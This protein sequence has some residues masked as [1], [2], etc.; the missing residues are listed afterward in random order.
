MFLACLKSKITIKLKFYYSCRRQLLRSTA[1][2]NV[3]A[4]DWFQ[5]NSRPDSNIIVQ[6]EI[7]PLNNG[8]SFWNNK[9]STMTFKE[10]PVAK[11]W[12][13]IASVKTKRVYKM[14][15]LWHVQYSNIYHYIMTTITLYECDLCYLV[16]EFYSLSKLLGG[17]GARIL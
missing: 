5:G 7:L 2:F 1:I 3:I 9:K 16:Q 17:R 8:I 12:P 6:Q 4:V 11:R 13:P 15:M 14:R 10:V